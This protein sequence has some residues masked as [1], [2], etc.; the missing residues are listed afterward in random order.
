MGKSKGKRLIV[1]K[2]TNGSGSIDFC[3]SKLQGKI[4]GK[5]NQGPSK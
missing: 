4:I 5:N 2:K 3:I 1:W